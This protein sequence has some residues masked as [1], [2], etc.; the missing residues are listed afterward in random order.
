M[1][2][3]IA[4]PTRKGPKIMYV[5]F[6]SHWITVRN[7]WERAMLAATLGFYFCP[8]VL[9]ISLHWPAWGKNEK[10]PLVLYSY[11]ILFPTLKNREIVK[12]GGSSFHTRVH[13]S[14]Y[15]FFILVFLPLLPFYV[16]IKIISLNLFLSWLLP[17]RNIRILIFSLLSSFLSSFSFIWVYVP[18]DSYNVNLFTHLFLLT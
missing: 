4:R 7:R 18:K 8:F 13:L 1:L 6:V 3:T 9:S 2:K 16:P 17:F 11:S 14:G 15:T 5:W 10:I 12:T